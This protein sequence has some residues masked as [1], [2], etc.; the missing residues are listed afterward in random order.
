MYCPICQ[1]K[2]YVVIRIKFEKF[3]YK[4]KELMYKKRMYVCKESPK[5]NRIFVGGDTITKNLSNM[6]KSIKELQRN[7]V[8]VKDKDK[9]LNPALR[10]PFRKSIKILLKKTA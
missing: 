9:D 4:G 10:K 7:Y 2:H 1:K 5:P 3:D 6:R 8:V